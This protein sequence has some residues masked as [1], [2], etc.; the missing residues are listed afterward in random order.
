M[1]SANPLDFYLK[2]YLAKDSPSFG[3]G[4]IRILELV[5]ENGSLAKSYRAMGLSAS[6]GWRI[7]KRAEEDLGFEL[8]ESFS[9]GKDGGQSR[10]SEKGRELLNNYKSFSK[11]LNELSRELFK[12]HFKE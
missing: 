11:E 2:I 6:K 4:V 8:L 1:K 3:P 5:Q 12:K 9:G 7:I 10:L